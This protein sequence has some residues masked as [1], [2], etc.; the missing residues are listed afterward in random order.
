MNKQEFTQLRLISDN[1]WMLFRIYPKKKEVFTM[2]M[3]GVAS[4]IKTVDGNKN[5]ELYKLYKSII[6]QDNAVIHEDGSRTVLPSR[7]AILSEIST[8]N[9]LLVWALKFT[10][11]PRGHEP[12]TEAGYRRP[13]RQFDTT[14]FY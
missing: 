10:V 2:R 4:V 3:N 7:Q 5:A 8:D 1:E 12:G 11:A 9:R 13:S 14:L 6:G